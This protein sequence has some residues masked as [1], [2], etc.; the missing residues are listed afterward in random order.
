MTT[1]DNDIK[2]LN[3]DVTRAKELD[4]VVQRQTSELEQLKKQ[5][6]EQQQNKH[7]EENSSKIEIRNLQNALDSSKKEVEAQRANVSEFKMQIEDLKKQLSESQQL[8]KSNSASAGDSFLV[9]VG[10]L[11]SPITRFKISTAT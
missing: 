6:N 7:A 10:F 9:S 1:R 2:E 4:K 8:A 3:A 5:L 11:V